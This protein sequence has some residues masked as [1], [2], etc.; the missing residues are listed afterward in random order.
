MSDVHANLPALE[1]VLRA[2]GDDHDAVWVLGDTVGYGAEPDA[3]V[4]RLRAAGAVAVRGN[5]DHVA[6]G[7]EGA[8]WFNP[9]ARTA[10]TWTARTITS[11]TRTWLAALPET[12]TEGGC[13]LVHGSPRDPLWEYIDGAPVAGA[14]LA[15]SDGT[16]VL[17]GHTHV[18]R[19]FVGGEGGVSVVDGRDRGILELGGRAVLANPGSVGQPRDGDPRASFLSLDLDRALI[20]WRRVTYD[21]ATAAAGIRAAGLPERLAARLSLGT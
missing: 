5:H 19:A 20:T 4:S 10:I 15:E 7:G 18:P 17:F 16:R 2:V 21:I 14:V 13:M 12:R 11:T 6:G 3:V 1:A 8:D 9:T